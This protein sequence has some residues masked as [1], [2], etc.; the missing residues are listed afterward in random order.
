MKTETISIQ[1]HLWEEKNHIG[2][3]QKVLNIIR[4]KKQS[5]PLERESV[6]P[7]VIEVDIFSEAGKKIWAGTINPRISQEFLL[8][9]SARMGALYVLDKAGGLPAGQSSDAMRRSAAILVEDGR[10]LLSRVFAER[11]GVIKRK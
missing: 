10:V 5:R 1:G 11:I 9:F 2:K 3:S 7:T 4:K 8:R 6:K